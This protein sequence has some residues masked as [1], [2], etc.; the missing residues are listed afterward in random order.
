MSIEDKILS[1]F[2]TCPTIPEAVFLAYRM[3]A[4]GMHDEAIQACRKLEQQLI[5]ED[6]KP[7][8]YT[9]IHGDV[10]STGFDMYRLVRELRKLVG[11][12]SVI[13]KK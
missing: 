3:K 9:D 7:E 10:H 6:P 4:C 1:D 5:E 8:Y 12:E 2:D 13:K 11:G